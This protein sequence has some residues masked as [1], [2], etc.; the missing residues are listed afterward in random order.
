MNEKV[1]LTAI[2]VDDEAPARALIREY[3]AEHSDISVVAE[4]PN[5]FNR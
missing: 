4:C 5:G 2:V 3:L 1:Q